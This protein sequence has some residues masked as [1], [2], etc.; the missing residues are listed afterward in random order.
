MQCSSPCGESASPQI[1]MHGARRRWRGWNAF[2]RRTTPRSARSASSHAA[3]ANRVVFV[4]G[5]HDAALAVS[6][7]RT[8]RHRRPR[9]RAGGRVEVS[10]IRVL[11]VDGRPGLRRARPSDRPQRAPV[12]EWPPPFVR[13]TVA[14][15]LTRPWGEQARAAG[16]TT[17]SS[18][19]SRSSTTSRRSAPASSTSLAA[20]GSALTSATRRSFLR[21]LLFAD[22][23]AAVPDGAGRWRC[24]AADVGSRAGARA[25]ACV[26]RVI[27]ARRRSVQAAGGEGAAPTAGSTKS[28]E[29]LTDE[30]IVGDLRLSRR[31]APLAAA[32]RTGGHAVP[33]A[34]A[35]RRRMSANARDARRGLRLFLAVARSDVFLAISKTSRKRVPGGD[36]SDR[37]SSTATRICRIARSRAPT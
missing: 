27:A 3:G 5:D 7:G 18:R 25:R 34:G 15:H 11:A 37:C 16:S 33:A 26:P 28:M 31:R 10:A 23:L 35:G 22:V 17:A 6:S 36:A 30:E 14:A 29:Q 24:A 9:R 19:V 4:P 20:D 1:R 2:W 21:Y 12:R 13:A 8:P 32:L